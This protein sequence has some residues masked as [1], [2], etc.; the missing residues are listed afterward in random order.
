[1]EFCTDVIHCKKNP[2]STSSLKNL[3]KVM[4]LVAGGKAGIPNGGFCFF[5]NF[6]PDTTNADFCIFLKYQ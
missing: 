6:K 3:T 5:K 4:R 2:N 1:M